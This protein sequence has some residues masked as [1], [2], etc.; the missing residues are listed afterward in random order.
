[1][2]HLN[3]SILKMLRGLLAGCLF[4]VGAYWFVDSMQG[5]YQGGFPVITRGEKGKDSF[6]GILFS[7]LFM[8]Y[9]AWELLMFVKKSKP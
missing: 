6:S 8:L 3:N 1:M 4:S 7:V 9:G 2:E 5:W